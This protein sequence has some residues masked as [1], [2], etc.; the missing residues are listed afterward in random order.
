MRF[1]VAELLQAVDTA[2]EEDRVAHAERTAKAEAE[3]A[4]ERAEWLE[5]RGPE[6]RDFAGKVRRRLAA[7]KPITMADLPTDDHRLAVF[8]EQ[9]RGWR[10]PHRP[11]PELLVLQQ[12]L[13]TLADD[14]VTTSGLRELGITAAAMRRAV[15]ALAPRTAT[16]S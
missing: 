9:S 6:W 15:T 10:G 5:T 3:A 4:Q 12:V 14:T 8:R 16:S 13:R 7:R 2:L 1:K 11:N